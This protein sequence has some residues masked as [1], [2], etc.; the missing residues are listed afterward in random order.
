ME[1]LAAIPLL[2]ACSGLL[3]MYYGLVYASIQDI[4]EPRSRGTAMSLYFA[5]MYLCGGAFGPVLTG[6]LSDVLA[7][8]A[9]DAGAAAEAARSVG[10]QQAM[11]IIPLL[12]IGLA[13]VL[14]A[15]S[16]TIERDVYSA[17]S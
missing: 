15:G 14:W 2:V 10:L 17:T 12:C 1:F 6:R 3:N 8:R 5:A 9:L 4:V 13:I 16:R 7:R 11:L